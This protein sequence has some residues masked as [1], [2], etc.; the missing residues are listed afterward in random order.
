M[1]AAMKKLAPLAALLLLVTACKSTMQSH[2]KGKG[3]GGDDEY[4]GS[5]GGPKLAY[6]KGEDMPEADI[7]ETQFK[8]AGTDEVR[9]V[10]FE[11]DQYGLGADAT[12]ALRGNAEWLKRTGMKVLV[13]GHA[14][15]RGTAEY[16]LALGQKRAKTV[17]EYY[18]RA[19]VPAAKVGTISYGKE[20][21]D[22]T[23]DYDSCG[24]KNRRALTLVAPT[25]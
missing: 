12:E 8:S 19:G 25:K 9:V 20:R 6:A 21:P 11:Y 5:A 1:M 3:A 13:E 23:G 4:A 16:N 18:V 7:R 17:R 14:D 24:P 2:K 15:E 10:Y 22:C